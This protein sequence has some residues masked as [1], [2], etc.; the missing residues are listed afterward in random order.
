MVKLVTENFVPVALNTDRLPDT[1]AGKFFCNL[2]RQW[3]QGLWVVTTDGKVLGFH[4]H[5]AK[6][7][8]SYGDG[9]KRWLDETIEMLRTAAKDA[10]PLTVRQVKEK[11]DPLADRGRGTDSDGAA[12]LAVSVVG[13]QNGRRDGPPVVDS[14]QLSAEQWAAFLPPQGK[15]TAGAEWT[16]P[17]AVARRFAPAA[18]PDDGYH[19]HPATR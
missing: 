15:L 5:K 14:I 16:V 1:D 10:G 9:Q 8:E 7:G 18:R 17:E 13:L 19:L 3:P 6:P 12:R 4:Y 2:M 11:P